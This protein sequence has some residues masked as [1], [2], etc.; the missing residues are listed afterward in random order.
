MTAW[1][2]AAR[3][4]NAGAAEP[5]TTTS[6]ASPV[7]A[8][9]GPAGLAAPPTGK[10]GL[11]LFHDLINDSFPVGAVGLQDLGEGEAGF[12][13]RLHRF[14]GLPGGLGYGGNHGID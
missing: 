10:A 11:D 14:S 3:G 9:P 8:R 13:E 7:A 6:A 4:S 12:S 1:L 2:S 5:G